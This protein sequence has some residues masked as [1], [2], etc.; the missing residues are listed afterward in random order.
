MTAAQPNILDAIRSPALFKPWFKKLE[1][2]A[3][4]FVF[5]QALFALPIDDDADRAIFTECTGR[6]TPPTDPVTEGWLVVGR[7]G[8]KSLILAVIA[9]FLAVFRDW[10]AHL[11]PGESALVQVIATDR[12]QAR[13]IY[14]YARAM[15]MK[16]PSLK[17]LV[18][19]ETGDVIEL[20]TGISI[21][22]TTAS[23]RAV[24]G[25]T[26]V[27]ALC[28]EI[29]FWRSDENSANP[30]SEILDALR[31]AMATIPGAVLLGASSPYAKRGVLWQAH[32]EHHGKDSPV[33]VW[34]APTL[35][36]NPT[37]P[38]SLI[39]RAYDRDP[40]SA[41][42]EYGAEFRSDIAAFIDR[43][44]I[45]SVTVPDRF[46]LPRMS[47]ISY[48]AFV[49]PSGGSS[50]S[51]TLAIAHTEGEAYDRAVLDA[52]REVRPPFSPE[53]VVKE[54]ATLLG[55]YEIGEVEGDR[56]AGEWPRERFREHG[57][58]YVCAE[59]PKSD[60]YK[61]LLPSLNSGKV[62]LLDHARLTAQLCGLE[63]RTARGGRDSIDHSPGAH[64]DLANSVAGALVRALTGANGMSIWER[65]I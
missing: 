41:A 12:K 8:G 23:Y 16:V 19:S 38:K 29:A 44:V 30:D 14:R 54:F 58:T 5:L 10:S 7:R 42:A 61:E 60:I 49:D 50:D 32:R 40:L 18:A 26:I 43:T 62:E 17:R 31:P 56:Y 1:T 51:M 53:S 4:W 35:R 64:D 59:K 65:L 34:Q 9:V 25:Y 24:R 20:T 46:E 48:C 37:V 63:R 28:D 36:M 15:L 55:S 22:I 21:E 52:V 3:A 2:W 6:A 33:L 11:V 27:A 39:D 13:I 45:D 47:S 57:I